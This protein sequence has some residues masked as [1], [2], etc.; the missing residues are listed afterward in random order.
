MY[1]VKIR[2]LRL[3]AIHSSRYESGNCRPG[4]LNWLLIAPASIASR[5]TVGLCQ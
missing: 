2:R 4:R 3:P 5:A 1:T